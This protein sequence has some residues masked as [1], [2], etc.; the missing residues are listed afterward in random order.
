MSAERAP[1][2]GKIALIAFA[3]IGEY[4]IFT[5]DLSGLITSWNAGAQKILGYTEAEIVGQPC[6]LIFVPEDRV[7]GAPELERTTALR[8]GRAEDLRWHLRKDGSRFWGSGNMM[9]LVDG[10]EI[11]GF[12][13]VL[14]DETERK[15]AEEQ[16]Q[17][18][19]NELNH[20]VKNT[21]ATV[22]SIASQT[23]RAGGVPKTVRETLESRL[24]SLSEAHNILTRESWE[25]AGVWEIVRVAVAAHTAVEN[26][27]ARFNLQ[28]ADVW[29]PPRI[30]V[31]LALALHELATNAL[32]YGA[33]S[34]PHGQIAIEWQV[35]GPLAPR[36]LRLKW[37]ETGGPTV[38]PPEKRG[39][40]SR[41]IESGLA[42]ELGG[43]V[44]LDF[45]PEGVR[46]E[47]AAALEATP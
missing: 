46:C 47:M 4:A 34:V 18:L 11:V 5:T 12:V 24:A 3:S 42:A 16:R 23:L 6:D 14:R 43:A 41:L 10:N 28:G 26:G 36:L 32:K 38:N 7:R 35:E 25:G 13:K 44:R 20:R 17:L 19:L 45:R 29:V 31:A 21:L 15:R 27:A 37:R 2:Q 22:Q 40:G 33:L 9:S 39:F 30:A 8:D 1:D